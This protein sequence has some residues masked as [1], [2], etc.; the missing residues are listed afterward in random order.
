MTDSEHSLSEQTDIRGPVC[1]ECGEEM[2]R[3]YRLTIG[4]RVP[5]C[6]PNRHLAVDEAETACKDGCGYIEIGSRS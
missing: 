6:C 1:P 2:H 3:E 4:G 5:W